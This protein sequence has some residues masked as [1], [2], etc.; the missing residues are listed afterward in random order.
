MN[1][2]E[3]IWIKSEALLELTRS[4]LMRYRVP[5]EDA[6]I[7]ADCLISANLRGVDTHGIIRLKFYVDRIEAGGNN[8]VPSIRIVRENITTALMDGD[9]SLGP[10]GGYRAMQLAIDKAHTSGVGLVTIRNSNHY[11]AAAYYSMMALEHDMI[12][13][14]MTNVLASMPPTGGRQARVGNNPVSIAFPA[15]NEFPIVLDIATSLSSWGA[16][17]SAAQK[18]E[19]LPRGCFLDKEGRTTVDPKDV[20][21]GGVLLPIAGYKGYGIALCIGILTGLLSDAPFDID[22][23]HPYK[24]LEKPGNNAFFMAAIQVDQFLPAERF[25][26]Q[27]DEVVHRIHATEL[28]PGSD[29]IYLPGEKEFETEKERRFRGI[30]LNSKM[31]EELKILASE[32]KK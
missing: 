8:P 26:E 2:A 7:I 4:I 32:A 6:K 13:V 22:I 3:Q 27:V 14:S 23:P 28:A 30:P 10:V 9:N 24:A 18:G 29:H 16:L 5:E 25:K 21:D 1:R 15:R 12:G 20:L 11:G 31:V 17:F 19:P